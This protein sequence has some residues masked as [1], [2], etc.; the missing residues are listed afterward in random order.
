M[1]QCQ[2]LRRRRMC[3]LPRSQLIARISMR[4][5]VGQIILLK[6]LIVAWAFSLL[7]VFQGF[8]SIFL[9]LSID[10]DVSLQTPVESPIFLVMPTF[11]RRHVPCKNVFCHRLFCRTHFVANFPG[12]VQTWYLSKNLYDQIFGQKNFTYWKRVNHYYFCQQ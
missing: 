10:W 9:P 2:Y 5:S 7:Q 4:R 11:P 3:G 1:S 8:S 12:G 6:Q